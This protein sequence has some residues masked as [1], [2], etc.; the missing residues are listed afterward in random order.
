MTSPEWMPEFLYSVIVCPLSENMPQ[1]NF[2]RKPVCRVDCFKPY[3][4]FIVCY[5]SHAVPINMKKIYSHKIC[6]RKLII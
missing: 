4:F 6:I 2:V 3:L 5:S 1:K